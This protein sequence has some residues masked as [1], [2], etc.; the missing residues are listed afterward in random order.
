MIRFMIYYISKYGVA[1]PFCVL[2]MC[3]GVLNVTRLSFGRRIY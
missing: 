1:Q 3:D 2:H